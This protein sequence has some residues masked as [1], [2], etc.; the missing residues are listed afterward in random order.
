M[1]E[2]EDEG[3]PKSKLTAFGRA[4]RSTILWWLIAAALVAGAIAAGTILKAPERPV[5]A[6]NH[7]SLQS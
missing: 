5:P 3:L 4:Y 1:G 2:G 6:N 7:R